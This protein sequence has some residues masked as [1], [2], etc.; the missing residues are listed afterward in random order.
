MHLL[1]Q[2]G[3]QRAADASILE[4]HQA[5]VFLAYYASLLDQ[6]GID[7]HLANVVDDHSELDALFV[8]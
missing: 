3:P 1:D 6:V 8:R 7:V 4:R 5:L 2:V